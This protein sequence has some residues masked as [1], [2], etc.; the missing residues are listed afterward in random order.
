MLPVEFIP[1][2]IMQPSVRP[3]RGTNDPDFTAGEAGGLEN[4]PVTQ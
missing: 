3:L 4:S 1:I 2:D